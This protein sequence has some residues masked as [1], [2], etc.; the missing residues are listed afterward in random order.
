MQQF[1]SINNVR[2]FQLVALTKLG[3]HLI[4]YTNTSL[5]ELDAALKGKV[6]IDEKE[7]CSKLD[8]LVEEKKQLE[9]KI[10]EIS[11]LERVIKI[12]KCRK[13]RDENLIKEKHQ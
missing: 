9:D 1:F 13:E 2:N 11:Q 10:Q 8:K 3:I 12:F 4:H 7:T 6:A 5:N